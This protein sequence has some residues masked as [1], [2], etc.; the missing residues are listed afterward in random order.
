MAALTTQRSGNFSDTNAGTMPWTAL[1]GSGVGGIPAAGDTFTVGSGHTVTVDVSATIGANG[2]N[3]G[4]AFTL[5]GASSSSFGTLIVNSGVTLTL[6]GNDT[7]SN[8]MGLINQYAQFLPQSGS[9]IM[10]DPA[11]DFSTILLNRGMINATG[12]TFTSTS[13]CYTWATQI[14]NVSQASAASAWQ[15]SLTGHIGGFRLNHQWIANAAGTGLGSFGDS[16]LSFPGTPSPA[17]T[18]EVASIAAIDA[19]GK[20]FVDYELGMVMAYMT[21]APTVSATYKYLVISKTWSIQTTQ[22]TSY[23]SLSLSGC[24]VEYLGAV[25]E[26]AGN[27]AAL[28]FANRQTDGFSG[29]SGA[30]TR[31]FSLTGNT[32]RFCSHT[33]SIL[34]SSGT[35]GDMFQITG[36]TFGESRGDSVGCCINLFRSSTTY[37]NL[38]NNTVKA[39]SVF[40][41]TAS[42][43]ALLEH[44]G[45]KI[46]NNNAIALA[47]F[48]QSNNT[49]EAGTLNRACWPNS[50]LKDNTITGY[51]VGVDGYAVAGWGGKSGNNAIMSGN[52]ISH[53]KRGVALAPYS[54]GYNNKLLEL[55]H[56]H[57]IGPA[58]SEDTYMVD[59]YWFNNCGTGCIDAGGFQLGYNRRMWFDNVWVFNN[60]WNGGG[61]EF[62]DQMDNSGA[63]LITRCYVFNNLVVNSV[64]TTLG[65]YAKSVESA[66]WRTRQ[67]VQIFE[68][69]LSYNPSPSHYPGWN[70]PSKF[71]KSGVRYNTDATRNCVGMTLH[72][73][74]YG[75][76]QGTGRDFTYTINAAGTD[77]TVTWGGGTPVQLIAHNRLGNVS[78]DALNTFIDAGQSF[79]TAKNNANAPWCLFLKITSGALAGTVRAIT[80]VQS[81]TKVTVTPIWNGANISGATNASPISITSAGHGLSTGA[82]VFILGVTGNTAANG[83]F[84]ITVTGANTFTLDGST[85]NGAYT[86][87]PGTWYAVPAATDTYAT[88][89]TEVKA[90][91]SGG[92]NYVTVG[93]DPRYLPA[94]S[95]TDTGITMELGKVETDPKLVC[96]TTLYDV[97]P[98]QLHTQATSGAIDTGT[99][100]NAPATDYLGTARPSGAGYD[101]GF[102][103]YAAASGAG[104]ISPKKMSFSIGFSL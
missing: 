24:T 7:T 44:T 102:Y 38:S 51:G 58:V 37:V 48:I 20:Y 16:S 53:S 52:T 8:T 98:T 90:Y 47:Y 39:R 17:L 3:V 84:T 45:W 79:P 23:N 77:E 71:I 21:G 4:H 1:T 13:G 67:Q 50:L 26:S 49:H 46:E 2:S 18:T 103:E 96:G 31:K 94:S 32:F 54:T 73:T 65:S 72:D 6:R 30:A 61:F 83:T 92:S 93:P 40:L 81:S 75:S 28:H 97:L 57:V 36:N 85:G 59:V 56:H 89:R 91:D 14:T 25:T 82:T 87:N 88:Y 10:G 55:L 15:Y 12:A 76:D 41:S 68:N 34:S 63:S 19:V 66:G 70:G 64:T 74:N 11:G 80:N 35:S 42:Y 69:N 29:L 99:S 5:A 78:V 62:G 86:G 101:L 27:R 22:N 43:A 9:I 100:E 60:T 95:Q 33:L 104:D